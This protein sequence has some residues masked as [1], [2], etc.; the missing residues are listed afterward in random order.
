V[1]DEDDAWSKGRD[2]ARERREARAPRTQALK[3]ALAA[4]KPLKGQSPDAIRAA[5]IREMADRGVT[6]ATPEELDFLTQIVNSPR[7]AATGLIFRQLKAFGAV[8]SLFRELARTAPPRW[9]E[10]P[11]D[12]P[13]LISWRPDQETVEIVLQ[14]REL[15]SGHDTLVRL[16]TDLPH[17]EPTEIGPDE[18]RPFGCWLSHEPALNRPEPVKIHIGK[19]AIGE[20]PDEHAEL[21][22]LLIAEHGKNKHAIDIVAEAHGQD[23]DT[24]RLKLFLP[25]RP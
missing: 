20:L 1:P 14:A 3:D 25:D 21:G 10:T 23:V 24:G 19:H 5:L 9:T 6:D 22:R 17:E 11:E 12:I 2:R 13:S 7:R 18:V 16:F 4:V 8:I 15:H